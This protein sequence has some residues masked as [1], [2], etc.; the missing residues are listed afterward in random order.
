MKLWSAALAALIIVAGTSSNGQAPTGAA[1]RPPARQ[2]GPLIM[3]S[4]KAAP[5]GWTGVHKPHTKLVD[6][7]ARH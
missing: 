3:M 6:V 5:P 4:P 7:L 2:G 1:Q